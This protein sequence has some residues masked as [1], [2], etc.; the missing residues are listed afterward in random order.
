MRERPAAKGKVVTI[1]LQLS[2]VDVLSFSSKTGELAENGAGNPPPWQLL[3]FS[4][5]F[6][7]LFL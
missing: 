6:R 5:Q 7:L 3:K 2:Y 4:L 1:K